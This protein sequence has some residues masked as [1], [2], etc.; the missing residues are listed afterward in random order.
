MLLFKG[1]KMNVVQEVKEIIAESLGL[2]NIETIDDNITLIDSG[3][4][5]LEMMH[6]SYMLEKK[7]DI[8]IPLDRINQN[9]RVIDF[10]N[11][12]KNL[13]ENRP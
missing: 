5:S 13:I 3:I 6:I 12:V 9:F 4:D 7:Y 8:A 1:V 2:D 11:L 10:C